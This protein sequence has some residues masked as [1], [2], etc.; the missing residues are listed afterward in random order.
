MFRF[1]LA[2]IVHFLGVCVVSAVAFDKCV[3]LSTI[4]VSET[5]MTKIAAHRRKHLITTMVIIN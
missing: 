4:S 5:T 1:K 2:L 3:G